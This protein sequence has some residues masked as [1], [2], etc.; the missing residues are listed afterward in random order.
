CRFPEYKRSFEHSGRRSTR[1]E[2]TTWESHKRERNTPVNDG[3]LTGML[4]SQVGIIAD[5]QVA[6]S[7][8]VDCR[9]NRKGVAVCRKDTPRRTVAVRT[10]KQRQRKGRLTGPHPSIS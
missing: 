7:R 4:D 3:H 6:Q 1:Q 8:F 5:K 9:I 2:R 10:A